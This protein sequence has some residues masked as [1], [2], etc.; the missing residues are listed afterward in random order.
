MEAHEFHVDSNYSFNRAKEYLNLPY[1]EKG[2]R[3]FLREQYERT[4]KLLRK[5]GVKE[6]LLFRGV[7]LS[8]IDSAVDL[9][10]MKVRHKERPLSSWSTEMG[11]ASL[12]ASGGTK[13]ATILMEVVPAELIFSTPMTGIG[14]M[15][16]GE[17]VTLGP[18]RGRMGVAAIVQN[19]NYGQFSKGHYVNEIIKKALDHPVF[20]EEGL[21]LDLDRRNEMLP[22][23]AIMSL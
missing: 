1:L 14:C 4:Q 5:K 23:R 3:A 22:S 15:A 8:D 11:T 19:V 12:F 16:E 20:K 10:V 2:L 17:I 13:L 9:T 21:F 18:N 6:L 7:K